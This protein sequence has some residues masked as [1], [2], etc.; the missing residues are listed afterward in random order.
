LFLLDAVAVIVAV[1]SLATLLLLQVAEGRMSPSI[2]LAWSVD[3]SALV[4]VA[5]VIF[6]IAAR[7]PA[8]GVDTAA[9]VVVFDSYC[10]GQSAEQLG[11]GFA[12]AARLLDWSML[13]ACDARLLP[14][15]WIL[16]VAIGTMAANG[17]LG[18]KL[19]YL[20]VLLIS[21]VGIEL[22]T[23]AMRQGLAATFMVV[24]LSWWPRRRLL[25]AVLVA[26]AVALHGSAALALLAL[27]AAVLAWRWYAFFVATAIVLVYFAL[28][29]ELTIGPIGLFLYEIQKYLGHESDEVWIR[30]LSF[31]SLVSVLAIPRLAA[32]RDELDAVSMLHGG[33]AQAAR[34]AASSVPFMLLPYFGYRYIYGI[35]PLALWLV[36]QAVRDRPRLAAHTFVMLLLANSTLLAVWSYGSSYMRSIPL[37][38]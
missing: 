21:L 13:G 23:N 5:L 11:L 20:A 26:V 38:E 36:L 33:Y 22:T 14:M 15:A 1:A 19:R 27:G 37:F 32:R 34:L 2:R 30:V 17:S 28:Q 35:F 24:A 7:N 4:L 12:L 9:Y 16:F 25:S 18:D 31:A 29:V 8:F 3:R 6:L 10:A